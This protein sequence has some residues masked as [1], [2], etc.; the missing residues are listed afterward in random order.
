MNSPP[1][2]ELST[3][4]KNAATILPRCLDSVRHLVT[5]ITIGDTGSSDSTVEVARGYG[6]QVVN[7]PWQN[8]FSQA[9][10]AV[11]RH[12]RADWILFLDADEILDPS[13]A[14]VLP[15]LLHDEGNL[16]YQF[17]IWNYVSS[18]TN[19][20]WDTP[21]QPNPHRLLAAQSFPA[22]VEH[23]NVRLFRRH[24]EIFF[25]KLV[26]EGVADRMR[27]LGFKVGQ[28]DCIIHHLGVAEDSAAER[29]RKNQLYRILGQE[30]LRDDPDDPLAHFELG[31]TELETFRNPAAALPYFE[32]VI[33]LTPGAHRA[34]TFA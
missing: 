10:N 28:A 27:R 19:R 11:L 9:R 3:I 4:V 20:F 31:I 21:A 34:W 18:L 6:A 29:L 2:V 25:E 13:A 26:H 17:P 33:D 7:V 12:A 16:G 15:A 14:T 5:H 24:P 23:K 32:R 30:K 8:N 22:Y 1:T